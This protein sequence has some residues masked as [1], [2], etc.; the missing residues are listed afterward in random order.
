LPDAR[1]AFVLPPAAPPAA[2][3]VRRA[4]RVFDGLR[5]LRL[6]ERLSS[7]PGHVLNTRYV[8]AAPNRMT[9][10]TDA[11]SAAIVIGNHRW[12]RQG[13]GK[14]VES[15]QSPIPQP[16]PFWIGPILNARLL[17][18]AGGVDDV[19][20][21][22]ARLKAWFRARIQER[23]GRTLETRMI[24]AAHFMHHRYSGFDAPT[25]ITPPR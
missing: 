6:Q 19:S 12:D 15:G 9:Y 7:G 24:A 17:G 8:F 5:S 4:T 11:G 25:R 1:V 23:T 13:R 2:A 22:D 3:I 20:F 14:W 16:R 21:Y 10:L 18:R